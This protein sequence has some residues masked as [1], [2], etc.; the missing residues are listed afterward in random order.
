MIIARVIGSAVSTA[1]SERL[2]ARKLLIV[3]EATPQNELMDRSPFVAVDVAGAG[4]G[5]LV[6][7]AVGSAGRYT[8]LTDLAPAD[9]AIV[10]ILDSLEIG[11]RNTFE[12]R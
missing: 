7:V 4:E 9:A 11:G 8:E 5:E 12:K 6:L 10:G 1:K 2:K 3:Q